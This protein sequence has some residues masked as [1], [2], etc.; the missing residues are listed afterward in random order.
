M[1]KTYIV[2]LVRHWNRVADAIHGLGPRIRVI[3]Y[4]DF[5]GEENLA[6]IEKICEP[7]FTTFYGELR[8]PSLSKDEEL[9]S[10]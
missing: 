7:L 9:E 4:E 8:E 6:K 1:R 2:R 5:F 3:R 10:F